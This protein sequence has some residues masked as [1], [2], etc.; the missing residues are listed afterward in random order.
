MKLNESEILKYAL[1]NCIINLDTILVEIEDMENKEILKNHPY[2]IYQGS[3]KKWRTYLAD[4]TKSSKRR[5]VKRNSKE[6]L[7]KALIEH[8][9]SLQNKVYL[10]QVFY[11]W[12]KEKI[13]Y[14]EIKPGT[15]DRYETD[16]QRFIINNKLN[17]IEV[18]NITEYMLKD[19]IKSTIADNKLNSKAW[20]NLRTLLNGMF[21]YAKDKGY[22]DI[23]IRQFMFELKLSKNA[24]SHKTKLDEEQV[25][26]DE[27]AAKIKEYILSRK[28]TLV[29]L[30]ILLAFETGLRAGELSSLTYEDIGK[31]YILV[32]K[33]EV[34]YKERNE[35]GFEYKYEVRDFPKTESSI[36]KVVTTYNGQELLKEIRSMNPFGEYIFMQNG[37]R[38][39]G[40]A[41]TSKLYRICESLGIEKRS[42]HKV[43]KT[44][45]SKLIDAGLESTLIEKQMGHCDI[46]TTEKY[47]HFMLKNN[48]EKRISEAIG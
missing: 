15:F 31:G 45:A 48:T 34:R 19:F 25:F 9:K 13:R 24:F 14:G 27:E 4:E 32:N 10:E 30:G 36:R 12:I 43:R 3:D 35:K 8:Y 18:K 21:G 22:S 5:V 11:E 17:E 28:H 1:T 29:G 47:Y 41:F 2:T 23:Q 46:S 33:T 16:F 40:K 38:I 7:E 37:S 6:D 42:L 39:K 20:G 44:Y 26:T